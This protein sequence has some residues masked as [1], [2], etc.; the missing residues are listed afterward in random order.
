M[1]KGNGHEGIQLAF[2]L[3]L[4]FVTNPTYGDHL[5]GYNP[6]NSWHAELVFFQWG[7]Y[8]RLKSAL[9]EAGVPNRVSSIEM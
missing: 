5:L 8:R 6:L 4:P 2:E 3:P 7:E 9:D 1:S